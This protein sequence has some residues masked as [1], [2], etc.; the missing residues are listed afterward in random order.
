MVDSLPW[1]A[2]KVYFAEIVN[3]LRIISRQYVEL[4]TSYIRKNSSCTHQAWNEY[5]RLK[6]I[7]AGESRVLEPV[8]YFLYIFNLPETNTVKTV[9]WRDCCLVVRYTYIE[10]KKTMSSLFQNSIFLCR[11]HVNW[12]YCCLKVKNAWI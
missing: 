1:Y 10:V 4:L 11:T 9:N 12:R 7:N 3:K 2:N 5:S 6:E 8:L